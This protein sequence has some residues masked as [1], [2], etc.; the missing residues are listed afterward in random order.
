M[1]A[2]AFE[3]RVSDKIV[4]HSEVQE[5]KQSSEGVTILYKDLNTGA[6]KEISGDYCI[7]TIP[8]PVLKDI[9]ADFSAEMRTAI[10][11]IAY[12]SA[13]KIGLQF[14]RRFWEEDEFIYGGSTLTNMDISSIYYPPTDYFAKKGFCSATMLSVEAR[15]N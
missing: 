15:I 2:K 12:A 9:K 4:F 1:I 10:S 7:C 6:G 8:L 14:K 13:G 3:K 11:K 5:I